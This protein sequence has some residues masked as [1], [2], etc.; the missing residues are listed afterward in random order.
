M[1]TFFD[2]LRIANENLDGGSDASPDAENDRG[3]ENSDE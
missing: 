3:K 1:T 2:S